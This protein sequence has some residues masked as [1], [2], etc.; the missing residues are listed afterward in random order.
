MTEWEELKICK[1]CGAFV[2]RGS[3]CHH[4]KA[5]S[6]ENPVPYKWKP[7]PRVKPREPKTGTVATYSEEDGLKIMY[8]GKSD[9]G[10]ITGGRPAGSV[11]CIKCYR[12]TTNVN[13]W[14]I[15]KRGV[16]YQGSNKRIFICHNCWRPKTPL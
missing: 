2:P 4:E 6:K 9:F 10:R 13:G 5:L 11:Y 7:E 8:Y 1:R 3:I 16:D 12:I 15:R 14:W